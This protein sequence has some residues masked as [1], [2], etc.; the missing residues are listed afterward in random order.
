M[1][2]N[3]AVVNT[4]IEGGIKRGFTLPGLGI[5]W[6]L[7]AFHERCR[8]FEVVLAHSEQCAS[9]MA[10]VTGKLTG[11]PGLF[12]A[13]GPF[14]TTT[15]AFGILEAY[16]S[17]SPMV[18]LTDTSCYDGFA[19]YGVYQ[20]MTGDYGAGDALAVLK[21]M[22]KFA[23]Y[24]T[25][26][27]EAVYG[28]QLAMKHAVI[29]R[30]GP[31]AVVMKSDIIL[32]ELPENP[33]AKL[34][35]TR[36]YLSSAPTH[37]DT[38][39]VAR[40]ANLIA[41][42]K[43]PI[44]IAGNGVFMSR[45]GKELQAFAEAHG[46]AVAS[47]YHG[48]GVIDE[49]SPVAVGMLGTWGSRAANR[50]MQAA[51]L[52]IM[53]GCSM[54]PEY[55]RFRDSAMIRPG[56]QTLIQVDIDPRNAGWVYPVDL[57]ITGDVAEVLS[58]L[59]ELPISSELRNARLSA[60]A[61]LKKSNGYG[62]IPRIPSRPGTVHY[63]DIVRALDAFLTPNDRLTLDAGTNRI[64]ATTN[65]C[66]RT[67]HQ[68]IAP[69]GIGGMGWSTPAATAVKLNRPGNRVTGV[70][71]D[72]GFVMTM[73][74]VATAAELNLDVVFL[75][76]NN[77]GLGMV[78]DNLGNQKIAVDFADHDLT[79]VAEGL[80]GKG[81]TVTEPDQIRDALEEAHKLGGPVVLDVKVDP[82]ASH[83]DCS[84]YGKL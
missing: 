28:M 32:Q 36:G 38:E 52:V 51:D 16:F 9:V 18:I 22:T 62:I 74:A 77:A 4:L 60:L 37:A 54:G 10:Q 5:T 69:G 27:E 63:A 43:R 57:A 73:D 34:Y 59:G 17:G 45:S 23:T 20:T 33:R 14:S 55:T 19:Q 66:L 25:K 56:E 82:A 21:T 61:E 64:W 30:P 71:G 81:L 79:K 76:A 75:V 1:R 35:P 6:S 84:D 72:G 47:S 39:A 2:T 12:M 24:A 7:R 50:A 83:R 3:E 49:T 42:A 15:G 80:G 46:I 68:L 31:A 29:P 58:M 78:R 13:Q 26:P 8:D 40:L 70:V 44:I 53:L 48:K 67:P 65:L 41:K 11:Q